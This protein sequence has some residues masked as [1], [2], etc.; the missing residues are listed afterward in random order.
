M[1]VDTSNFHLHCNACGKDVCLDK[2]DYYMLKDEVW[3]EICKNDYVD[4]HY[5]LCRECG[6]AFLG[7]KFTKADLADVPLNKRLDW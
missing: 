1:A 3:A 2:N 4:W 6:E 7:R 5:I